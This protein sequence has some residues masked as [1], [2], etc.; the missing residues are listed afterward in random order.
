VPDSLEVRSCTPTRNNARQ[1]LAKNAPNA[2]RALPSPRT[3]SVLFPFHL[4]GADRPP[5]ATHSIMKPW[6]EDTRTGGLHGAAGGIL[7]EVAST[8][9]R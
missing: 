7:V 6:P 9:T 2:G 1:R 5:P 8:K 3:S 4:R